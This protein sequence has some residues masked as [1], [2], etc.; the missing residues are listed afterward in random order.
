MK[1]TISTLV[2]CFLLLV[3]TASTFAQRTAEDY[4][5]ASKSHLQ[6]RDLDGALASLNK[7]IE[8]NPGLA[9]AYL[10][11]HSI[12]ILK[13]ALDSALGDLNKAI[14]IDPEIKQAYAARGRVRMMKNDVNG[15][16]SD[17]D[18]AIARGERSDEVYSAR[19]N[20]RIMT[21]DFEGAI[22]DFNIAISMNPKRIGHTLGRGL[23]R[24]RS[25]DEAGALADYTSI[26][27]SF[28][29]GER[30]RQAAGKSERSATPF[31]I[32]SPVISGPEYPTGKREGA[33]KG[34]TSP[35]VT[36]TDAIVAMRLDTGPGMTREK[37]EY[38]PSV[39]GAYLNRASI[40]G[41]RGDSDAALSDLNKSIII[42]PFF[43]AFYDRGKELRK[44][45]DLSAAT[46]D[47]TK[48][49]ELQPRM[50]WSYLERGTT[51]LRLGRED[52]AER[53]FAQTLA[54]E[55]RL[56]TT[57]DTRRAEAQGQR[58][59]KSP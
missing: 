32:T 16:L 37:M 31:D 5:S 57:V 52:E 14:L 9:V 54:L 48:A 40:Y 2:S 8:L 36:K 27:D 33:S 7:A 50:A 20:L 19:A 59:K 43:G 41:K 23:A 30:D 26:I 44:R 47:F 45:G 13:G 34:E 25:G 3:F 4:V 6:N 22:S 12:Y 17:F 51:L 10:E 28:E 1:R 29:Q 21:Q 18:N 35:G 49:I 46:A 42:E 55:P 39:A 56:K 38:L 53:D 24:S 58:E 11:R 15:A